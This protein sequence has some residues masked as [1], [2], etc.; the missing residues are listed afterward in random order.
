MVG[1][2]QILTYL[3]CVYLIFKGIEIFQISMTNE[4]SFRY[5]CR[6][7]GIIMVIASIFLA[8][9]FIGIIDNHANSI[10]NNLKLQENNLRG[11]LPK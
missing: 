6:I 9:Y 8:L 2:L 4:G 3:L 1:M 5:P 10:S 7:L 11:F